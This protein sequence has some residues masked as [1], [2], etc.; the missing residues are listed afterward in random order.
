MAGGAISNGVE[1]RELDAQPVLS[2][3]ATIPVAQL[4]EAMGDRMLALGSYLQ[5]RGAQVAGPPFVRYH[6]FG[7]TEAD[8]ETGVPVVEPVA[9]EGRIVSGALPGGPAVTTSHVG[10]HERLGEAYG[11][12]AEWMQEHGSEASGP[13]WEVYH[14]IDLGKELDPSSWAS[15][16]GRTQLVQPIK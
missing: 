4:G 10:A 7:E 16:A 2:I 12:I 15:P 5:E 13:G 9:G 11:R 1:V 3:R 14:W 6:M 8:M